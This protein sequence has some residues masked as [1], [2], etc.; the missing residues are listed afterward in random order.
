METHN[1]QNHISIPQQIIFIW[2]NGIVAEMAIV[3]DLN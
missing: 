2:G 3:I 1:N